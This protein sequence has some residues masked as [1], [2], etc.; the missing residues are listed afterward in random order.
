MALG[1]AHDVFLCPLG[2]KR[3]LPN[4]FSCFMSTIFTFEKYYTIIVL[5]HTL[6]ST[7]IGLYLLLK[8]FSKCITYYSTQ[9]NVHYFTITDLTVL[10]SHVVVLYC[11]RTS[12]KYL[13]NALYC[14]VP[15]YI[16]IFCT[17]LNWDHTV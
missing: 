11:C 3:H 2:H 6:L 4:K 10:L 8:K 15:C 1:F 9:I 17:V 16:V 7:A 13:V 14:T 12:L 5:H